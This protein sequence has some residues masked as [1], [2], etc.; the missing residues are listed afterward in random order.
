MGFGQ[1]P[2]AISYGSADAT[3]LFVMLLGELRRWGLAPEVVDRL[4]PHADRA[5]EWLTSFG[6]RD[7]D[8]YVEYQRSTDRGVRHQTWKDSTDPIRF[9]DG[10]P[11]R[12]WDLVVR[13][14]PM[15]RGEAEQYLRLK[16]AAAGRPRSAFT[17]EA[18]SRLHAL[19]RGVPRTLEQLATLA[20][21]A[22]ALAAVE[23]VTPDLVERIYPEVA[24]S[25]V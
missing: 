16:M 25:Q 22:G 11:A 2:G 6:D 23:M 15:S 5:L 21:M 12:P 17:P 10:R 24:A 4:L 20:L 13:L 8:G 7:G 18:V 3:P 9:P 19:S 1:G 14:A